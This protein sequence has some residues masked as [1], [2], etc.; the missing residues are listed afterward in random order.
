METVKRPTCGVKGQTEVDESLC[1]TQV[2][3][4]DECRLKQKA[5]YNQHTS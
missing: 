4:K 1:E 3:R 5:G 2:A